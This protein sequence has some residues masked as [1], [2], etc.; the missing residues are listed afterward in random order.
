MA[1]EA[2]T[3]AITI[4]DSGGTGRAIS[5]DVTNWDIDTPRAV[6]DVTGVD[7]S[8]VERLELLGDFSCSLNGVF[9]DASNLSHAVFKNVATTKALR[10]SVFVL[11]GQ[12]LTAECIFT[13]YSV[14]RAIT[15]E[16]T[17][18]APGVL[19][20]TTSFGWS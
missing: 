6:Q 2:P 18:A 8:S 1:K 5:N 4:D 16:L 9:N 17:W 19:A 3:V 15:A 7:V 13:G 10:T 14:A 12:T 11:S 20:A